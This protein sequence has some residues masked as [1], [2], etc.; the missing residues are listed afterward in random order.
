MYSERRSM[1]PGAVVWSGDGDAET[2]VLPDGC[3]DLLWLEDDLV[4]AGPDR[5]AYVSA[6]GGGSGLYGVR[7]ASG[8]GPAAFG[9]PAD[10]LRDRRVP[11]ADLWPS[12]EVRRLRERVGA[13]HDRAGALE[14]LVADRLRDS[15]PPDRAMLAAAA[16]LRGGA[17]V[18][19][20]AHTVGYSDRQLRRRALVAFGYGPKV[21]G[22]IHRFQR[23][24]D[25]V[26]GGASYAGAAAA[27]GYADQ[28]HLAREVRALAGVPISELLS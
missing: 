22:R 17:D 25:R 14:T 10:E 18:D 12:A 21:L 24:L 7:L 26:R 8:V 3:M 1:I 27:A 11:L 6:P 2:R 5:T 9:V 13:T 23:A 15:A 4:V 20:V 28:A 16:M 19:A